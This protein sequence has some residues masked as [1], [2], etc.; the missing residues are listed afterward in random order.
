MT[1]QL[2]A[3]LLPPVVLLLLRL[4]PQFSLA[5]FPFAMLLEPGALLLA[6]PRERS[7]LPLV[8]SILTTPKGWITELF[9]ALQLLKS[10]YRNGHISAG[11]K[12]GKHI[13]ALIAELD[14]NFAMT[15]RMTRMVE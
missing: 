1:I 2:R 4:W 5:L 6:A 9:E 8:L 14:P 7:P 11:A 13:D 10:A 12:A 3:R 15:L